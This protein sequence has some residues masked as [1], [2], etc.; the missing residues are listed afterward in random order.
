M[1]AKKPTKPRKFKQARKDAKSAAKQAFSGKSQ[2]GLKDRTLKISADD[3]KALSEIKNESRGNYITD[4]RGNKINVKPTETAQERFARDR[5]EAKAEI[6][7]KYAAEDAKSGRTTK[8]SELGA[9]RL[10]QMKKAGISEADAKKVLDTNKPAYQTSGTAKVTDKRTPAEKAKS[11]KAA[12]KDVKKNTKKFVQKGSPKVMDTPVGTNKP[13]VKGFSAGKTLTPK[14]QAIYDDLVK[15]GVKPKSA[16]NKAIFRQ[17]KTVSKKPSLPKMSMAEMKAQNKKALDGLKKD[18][19]A[20]K[21]S[22]TPKA[23]NLKTLEKKVSSAKSTAKKVT[24]VKAAK[25]ASTGAKVGKIILDAAK[26]TAMVAGPGKFLKAGALV[27]GAFAANKAVKV[28]KAVKA[29]E[30]GK[31]ISAANAARKAA[32]VAKAEKAAKAGVKGKVK[33]VGLAAAGFYALDKIPTGGGSKPAATPKPLPQ[34]PAGQYPKGGG[35]GLKLGPNVQV[36]AGGS[37]TSYTVK[38]GD[39]LSGIAK[40]SGVKLSEVLAANP[41]IADKKSKYKGGSMIW[42]GTKVKLPTKK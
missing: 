3:K 27:K 21:K 33:K 13:P 9:R 7:R 11:K 38:K 29:A 20:T 12:S 1:A 34:R 18:I 2:A 25:D 8:P 37:T 15:Q 22:T 30:S 35:K 14:G 32:N 16:M 36:N 26:T 19:D 28:T 10:E 41:K 39:T 4:D 23:D 6:D 31:K 42:S 17:E 40:T 24:T 5:R